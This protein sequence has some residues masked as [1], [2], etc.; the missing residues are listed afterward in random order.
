MERDISPIKN[1]QDVYIR[2]IC[3]KILSE[4]DESMEEKV[5]NMLEIMYNEMNKRF[6][7]V[8]TGIGKNREEITKNR[9]SIVELE[10]KLGGKIDALFDGYNQNTQAINRLETK[11]DALAEKVDKQEVEI[12]VIK[13]AK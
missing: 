6:D 13:G 3:G 12:R 9:T 4:G 5:F 1:K 2:A 8:N 10:N 7:E 11:F